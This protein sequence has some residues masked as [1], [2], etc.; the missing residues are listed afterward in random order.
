MNLE[1]FNKICKIILNNSTLA[2]FNR[3][4]RKCNLQNDFEEH[5][6][7]ARTFQTKK[8]LKYVYTS[9]QIRNIK[10]GTLNKEWT[11]LNTARKALLKPK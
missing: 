9:R 1:T 6:Q 7:N 2:G 5:R 8:I 4:Q 11:I 3:N 10:Y